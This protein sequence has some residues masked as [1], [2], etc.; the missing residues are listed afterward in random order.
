MRADMRIPDGLLLMG[1][2]VPTFRFRVSVAAS[3]KKTLFQHSKNGKGT[4]RVTKRESTF[5]AFLDIPRATR[6]SDM[7]LFRQTMTCSWPNL[8]HLT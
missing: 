6:V 5:V 8:A 7:A 4:F 1:G 3:E 2:V